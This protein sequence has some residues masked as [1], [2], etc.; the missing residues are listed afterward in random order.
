M[1][2]G[3]LYLKQI[4][5]FFCFLRAGW[6]F[7]LNFLSRIEQIWLPNGPGLSVHFKCRQSLSTTFQ[8]QSLSVLCPRH[9]KHQSPSSEMPHIFAFCDRR[10]WNGGGMESEA[11]S[12]LC[13]EAQRVPFRCARVPQ[14][15]QNSLSWSTASRSFPGLPLPASSRRN[16]RK[17]TGWGISVSYRATVSGHWGRACWEILEVMQVW[18]I[19]RYKSK[20]WYLF[21]FTLIASPHHLAHVF[22]HGA[23]E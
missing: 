14:T 20:C 16:T 15:P 11:A 6:G 7:P 17:Q 10:L 21:H 12:E 22:I 8:L 13:L 23:L 19:V 18:L 2:L 9:Q 5:F 3:T 4:S 1:E